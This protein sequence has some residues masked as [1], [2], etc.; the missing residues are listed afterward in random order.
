M[1]TPRERILAVYNGQTPDRVPY[2]LD[3]SHYYL[4]RFQKP[5]D[6]CNGYPEPDYGM[7]DFN[8]SMGAAFYMPNQAIFSKTQYVNDVKA[9]VQT[10]SVNGVPEIVWRYD[11]PLGSI[12]RIRVWNKNTYSWPIKKWGVVT[13]KEV[14][15]LAYAM[16]S[17]R[18]TPLPKNYDAWA[19]YVGDDGVVYLGA[20]YSAIGYLMS[21]WMGVEN[22]IYAIDDFEDVM[23]EA[24]HRINENIL[25][26]VRIMASE[27]RAPVIL[28]GDNFSSDVQPPSFFAQWSK[29]FYTK[30]IQIFHDHGKKVAVHVDG[31]QKGALA[32][33]RDA[34]ADAIDAVTPG[35]VGR[36]TPSQAR[37]EAGDKLILSGGIPNE[38]WYAKYAAMEQFEDAVKQW[39]ALKDLSPALIAAAGD[40]VPP[41]AEEA[42]IR[43]M[44]ELV[45][46]YG[47]Y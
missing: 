1:M 4:H 10:R 30:A 6:L 38:L 25:E 8:R 17:S 41:G 27:F 23:A 43:R 14:E 24:V 13:E 36:Y 18:Y 15:I 34:G 45:E 47:Y 42:R 20:G 29:D 31:K 35:S 44:G 39:L 32:M 26:Q 2:M 46:E 5:W 28:M 11:T 9:S 16:S 33:L 12:E 37:A 21:Y 3:L 22:T 7:I 19:D 40:Q